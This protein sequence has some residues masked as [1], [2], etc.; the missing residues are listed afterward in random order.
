MCLMK[1]HLSNR[2]KE[3]KPSSQCH[4]LV[5]VTNT[6]PNLARTVTGFTLKDQHPKKSP[7]PRE[8]GVV[9]HSK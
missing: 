9:D 3:R 6:I 7:N 2:E 4:I 8:S 1:K 5:G